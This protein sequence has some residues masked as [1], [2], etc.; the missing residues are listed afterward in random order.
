MGFKMFHSFPCRTFVLAAHVHKQAMLFSTL[1]TY[2]ECVRAASVITSR[3]FSGFSPVVPWIASLESREEKSRS[4]PRL[5]V[6]FL[7]S[8]DFFAFRTNT[9]KLSLRYFFTWNFFCEWRNWRRCCCRR[10]V[11]IDTR[12]Y[13]VAAS[14]GGRKNENL[15]LPTFCCM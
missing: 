10:C 12:Q 11:C 9:R 2:C 6:D 7:S 8:S 13:F 3:K 5:F 4:L 15:S 1:K 14:W